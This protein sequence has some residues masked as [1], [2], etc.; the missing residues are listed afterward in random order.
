M[1]SQ[2]NQ[3]QTIT[4]FQAL[5][6]VSG[7]QNFDLGLVITK[8]GKAGDLVGLMPA[9]ANIEVFSL[10]SK[11]HPDD[12]LKKLIEAL[13]SHKWFVLELEDDYMPGRIYNQLRL[14]ATTNKMEVVNLLGSKEKET[15]IKQSADSRIVVVTNHKIAK[16]LGYQFTRLFGSVLYL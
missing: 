8:N 12:A 6:T 15:V 10:S 3:I 4:Y 11:D 2:K 7:G 16:K 14:L 1:I 9:A 13:K 5:N